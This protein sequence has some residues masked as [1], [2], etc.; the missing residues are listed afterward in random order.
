[1]ERGAAAHLARELGVQPSAV[2]MWLKGNVPGEEMRPE[3]A[4]AL[5][6]SVPVCDAIR[7]LAATQGTAIH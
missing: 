5:K 2:S 1:M 3:I 6:I 7:T 4:K